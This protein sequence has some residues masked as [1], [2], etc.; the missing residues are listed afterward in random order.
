MR[1]LVLVTLLVCVLVWVVPNR[2]WPQ[3]RP[4]GRGGEIT[5]E[6]V[7]RVVPRASTIEFIPPQWAFCPEYWGL[8]R[9]VGWRLRE[10]KT[11]DRV[12][13]LESRCLA[14]V[15]NSGD[16]SGG[17]Y[18]LL[19]INGFWEGWLQEKNIIV[20]LTDPWNPIWDLYNPQTNLRAGLAIWRYADEKH[21]NGWGPWNQ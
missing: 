11:L 12:M 8:A 20:G 15:H 19:Q 2:T 18:G 21:G 4:E 14:W 13:W 3:P 1:K 6:K 5:L 10:M 7:P 16:P 17:S 9:S